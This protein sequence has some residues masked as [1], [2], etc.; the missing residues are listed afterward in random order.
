MSKR[1]D[2]NLRVRLRWAAVIKRERFSVRFYRRVGLA[3]AAWCHHLPRV[4]VLPAMGR[5]AGKTAIVTGAA[6]GIGAAT[7]ERLLSE[8][9]SVALFDLSTSKVH[10][11]AERLRSRGFKA[12][13]YI[14][15]VSSEESWA[16]AVA[17]TRADLG[18]IH[19]LVS[20]AANFD[21]SPAHELS[22]TSWD[23]QIAVNLTATLLGFKACLDD[24]KATRGSVV[25][26]SS[27][28][29]SLGFPGRAAYA[30]SKA[31][32]TG[33]GRQLAVEYAQAVRVNWVLPGPI[34]TPAWDGR[35]PEDRIVTEQ[36]TLEK[37]L[38]RPEEVA[39]TIVFLASDDASYITAQGIVVD[40]GMTAWRE[41][42]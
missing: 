40:G 29:A 21:M 37:R 19:V 33:L 41:G 27:V 26:V 16:W 38:G 17:K 4:S 34:L 15:D 10:D 3:A 6:G 30:A 22:R 35:S 31:G 5:F 36:T 23:H 28:H 13:S 1:V 7:V 25:L 14:C 11:A 9:A 12:A 18:P 2:S 42:I 20:N 32:L 8:G 24:L 39:A